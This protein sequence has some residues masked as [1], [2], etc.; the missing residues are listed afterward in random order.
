MVNILFVDD[1]DASL[2]AMACGLLMSGVELQG[3]VDVRV[4]SAGLRVIGDVASQQA[5]DA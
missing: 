3:D 5:M 2:A 4:H 1:G